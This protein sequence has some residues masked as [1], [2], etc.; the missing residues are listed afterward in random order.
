VVVAQLRNKFALRTKVKNLNL[1]TQH[2]SFNNFRNVNV[3]THNFFT[4]LGGLWTLQ[5][6]WHHFYTLAEGIMI[7]G[8]SL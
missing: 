4:F 8:R 1:K 6:A 7:S 3:H 5:S 2:S